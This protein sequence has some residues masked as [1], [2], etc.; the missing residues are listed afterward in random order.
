MIPLVETASKGHSLGDI[1]INLNDLGN[2]KFTVNDILN[3]ASSDFTFSL[4]GLLSEGGDAPTLAQ[5]Q[6]GL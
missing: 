5:C 4:K 3:D 1:F 6:H 2:V